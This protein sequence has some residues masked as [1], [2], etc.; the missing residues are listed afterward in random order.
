MLVIGA[1]V[2]WLAGLSVSPVAST[3][4]TTLLGLVGGL[5]A[6]AMLLGSNVR[7]GRG[8]GA[9]L[10]ELDARPVAVLAFSI[11]LFA[12]VGI[13]TRT[14]E[15]LGTNENASVS[16][17]IE[18]TQKSNWPVL[19]S[20]YVENCAELISLSRDTDVEYFREQVAKQSPLGR[21]LADELSDPILQQ[22]VRELCSSD[23]Q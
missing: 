6:G 15:L 10:A 23:Q 7:V 19:F 20:K 4:I 12:P 3:L 22:A 5:G 16:G 2:G 8:E 18:S 17:G 9:T 14:H 13:W 11:A 1:S 21:I